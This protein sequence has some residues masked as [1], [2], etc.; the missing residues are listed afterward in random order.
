MKRYFAILLA[1]LLAACLAVTAFATGEQLSHV[2]DRAGL[3][4]D[5]QRQALEQRA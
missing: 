1:L 4:T 5:E 2:I 3:F